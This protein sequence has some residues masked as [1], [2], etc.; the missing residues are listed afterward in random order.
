[1]FRIGEFSKIARVTTRQLR[2]YDECGLLH[3]VHIDHETSYRY[4]STSQLPRLNQILALKD[5]GLSLDQI[6]RSLNEDISVDELRGMLTM[7]KVQ[8]EKLVQ[9]ELIRIHQI[10]NR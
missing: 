9:E 10:E 3:P 8:L 7:K 4:Y 5:L 6:G 2:Y 1:M